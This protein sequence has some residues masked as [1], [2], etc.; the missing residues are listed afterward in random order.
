MA[1]VVEPAVTIDSLIS[2][3]VDP[4]VDL[5]LIQYRGINLAETDLH[6]VVRPSSRAKRSKSN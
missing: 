3:L 4:K 1:I 5:A 2:T 6:T